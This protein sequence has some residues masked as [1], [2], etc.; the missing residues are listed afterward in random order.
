[1]RSRSRRKDKAY[2]AVEGARAAARG[3]SQ[4][5]RAVRRRGDRRRGPGRAPRPG[6]RVPRA[7]R[8][9]RRRAPGEGAC[10]CRASRRRSGRGRDR[11]RG[12]PSGSA[13]CVDGGRG[14]GWRRQVGAGRAE[15]EGARDRR[16]A[17]EER[18]RWSATGRRLPPRRSSG[19]RRRLRLRASG[20]RRRRSRTPKASRR[21]GEAEGRAG[22]ELE[23]RER[24]GCVARRPRLE[25]GRT[26]VGLEGRRTVRAGERQ[27]RRR[28]S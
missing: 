14:G 11:V 26:E 22:T 2:Q 25:A 23:D 18:E 24:E 13:G 27:V 3:G 1:M 17:P 6:G 5:R 7:R 21:T 16:V 28:R 10:R 4:D 8:A 12:A 19:R 15:G 9:C 20:K